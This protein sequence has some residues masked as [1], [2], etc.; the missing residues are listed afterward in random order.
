[1]EKK[2]VFQSPKLWVLL[3]LA[4]FILIFFQF[5]RIE[6][7]LA[8]SHQKKKSSVI[9][10]LGEM[11]IPDTPDRALANRKGYVAKI[12]LTERL[13]NLP[14]LDQSVILS[15]KTLNIP[16]VFAPYNASIS[17]YDT[18][19]YLVFRY[20]FLP[21]FFSY[22]A[23]GNIGLVNLDKNMNLKSNFIRVE[24]ESKNSEDPRLLSD[25]NEYYL[26]YNDII[27]PQSE[28]RAIHLAKLNPQTGEIGSNIEINPGL[29]EIE[30]NWAPFMY[31]EAN[32]T[33][34]F[35]FE[36]QIC[37]PR[38]IMKL[39]APDDPTI[40]NISSH[41]LGKKDFYWDCDKWGT[42]LGGTPARLVDGEYLAFFHSKFI[43][44]NWYVWYVA[45]AY[46]FEAKPPFRVTAMS[47]EP[48]FFE[49]IY[50]SPM[51]NTAESNKQVFFP[52]GYALEKR[53]G[54]TLIHLSCGVNDS[55]IKI[56]TID[57]KALM[58]TLKKL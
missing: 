19:Y 5:F 56:V 39:A 22:R 24:T 35:C 16:G 28:N 38:R 8:T 11:D 57:K 9:S 53:E 2:A 34:H 48:I 14:L 20:D 32:G 12:R 41:N 18:G 42:P 25:G 13:R 23:F 50:D 3:S 47:A 51:L 27:N 15:T 37:C 46:T 4:L 10:S 43:D 7:H 33:K 1:M 26:V 29:R 54:R 6:I 21:N 58:K 45:G 44:E 55:A 17:E 49:H 31:K 30:K 40:V 36:Y 52:A